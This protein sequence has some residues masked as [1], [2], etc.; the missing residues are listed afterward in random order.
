MQAALHSNRMPCGHDPLPIAGHRISMLL[1]E[2]AFPRNHYENQNFQKLTC[3]WLR[4]IT[5]EI[6]VSS[7]TNHQ[8]LFHVSFPI[9]DVCAVH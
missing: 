2:E 4:Q 3:V 6:D 7:F 9:D 8:T 5:C 1:Q